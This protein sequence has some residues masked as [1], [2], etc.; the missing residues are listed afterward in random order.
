MRILVNVHKITLLTAIIPEQHILFCPF[1]GA[2]QNNSS[3]LDDETIDDH[4][5][6]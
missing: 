5:M 3:R 1:L 2:A 4:H 6:L